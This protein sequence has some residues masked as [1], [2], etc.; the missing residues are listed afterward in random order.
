MG[1][2]G[3]KPGA[4]GHPT[5]TQ[6]GPVSDFATQG[7]IRLRCGTEVRTAAQAEAGGT[8]WCGEQARQGPSGCLVFL[9]LSSSETMPGSRLRPDS[10]AR[11]SA[12]VGRRDRGG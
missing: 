6:Q 4:P 2:Q 9:F 8:S 1:T 11:A 7:R 5:E 3:D 10:V 12:S